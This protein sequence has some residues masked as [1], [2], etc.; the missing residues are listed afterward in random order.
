MKPYHPQ[1]R[2]KEGK[3]EGRNEIMGGVRGEKGGKER[4]RKRTDKPIHVISEKARFVG[5]LAKSVPLS[6]RGNWQLL[7]NESFICSR[8]APSPAVDSRWSVTYWTSQVTNGSTGKT[9]WYRNRRSNPQAKILFD[10]TWQQ[11]HLW[12]Y[13]RIRLPSFI[14]ILAQS[15]VLLKPLELSSL[16]EAEVLLF[17]E[18]GGNS[19]SLISTTMVPKMNLGFSTSL[20]WTATSELC[21]ALC[22]WADTWWLW[23]P[24]TLDPWGNVISGARLNSLDKYCLKIAHLVNRLPGNTAQEQTKQAVSSHFTLSS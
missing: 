12:I 15:L 2:K 7:Q 3:S 22:L 23:G 19:R 5:H 4:G 24:G 20:P 17:E 13:T 21:S 16:T 1:N 11:E 9:R 14:T 10:P 8:R 6:P 18:V